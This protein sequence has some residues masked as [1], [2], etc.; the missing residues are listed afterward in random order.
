MFKG[1]KKLLITVA[2]ALTAICLTAGL[3]FAW[4]TNQVTA[5][6]GSVAAGFVQ[7]ELTADTASAVE[8]YPGEDGQDFTFTLT[9]DSNRGVYAY[10]DLTSELQKYLYPTSDYGYAADDPWSV[11]IWYLSAD[12]NAALQALSIAERMAAWTPTPVTAADPV[13]ID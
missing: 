10:I 13:V 9:N 12:D 11:N 6:V 3:T 5:A 1:R 8:L 2:A 4:F 7:I